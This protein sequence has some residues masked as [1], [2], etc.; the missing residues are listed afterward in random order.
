MSPG[1]TDSL[2][3]DRRDGSASGELFNREIALPSVSPCQQLEGL[4]YLLVLS[5]TKQE[6]GSLAKADDSDSS[7]AHEQDETSAAVPNVSPALVV[8]VRASVGLVGVAGELGI[9]KEWPRKCGRE[10]GC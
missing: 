8:V 3:M 5:L 2:V 4:D 7:D 6:F 1:F 10:K 9:G